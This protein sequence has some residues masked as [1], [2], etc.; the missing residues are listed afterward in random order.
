[1]TL[2][3]FTAY[4]QRLDLGRT[5][6]PVND[7]NVPPE[8]QIRQWLA[9]ELDHLDDVDGLLARYLLDYLSD[10][11]HLLTIR[12]FL[13]EQPGPT[14][15]ATSTPFSI[16]PRR[17]ATSRP[18]SPPST[19]LDEPLELA[20]ADDDDLRRQFVEQLKTTLSDSLRRYY[21]EKGTPAEQQAD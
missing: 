10:G 13:S 6:L 15:A 9:A 7:P 18:P 3:L 5:S 11:S 4:L 8:P 12:Q 14:W 20:L 1:V 16:G 21:D 17:T 2:D 19:G